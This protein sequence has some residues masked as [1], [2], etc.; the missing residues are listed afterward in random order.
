MA[1]LH[2]LTRLSDEGQGWSPIELSE[3]DFQEGNSYGFTTKHKSLLDEDYVISHKTGEN[4][5][6]SFIKLDN[7]QV[8]KKIYQNIFDRDKDYETIVN[9]LGYNAENKAKDKNFCTAHLYM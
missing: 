5:W 2:D 4:I 7:G 6:V 9:H 3:K 8:Y 1:S